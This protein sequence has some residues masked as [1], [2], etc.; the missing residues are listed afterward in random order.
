M[1]VFM[2]VLLA[3]AVVGLIGVAQQPSCPVPPGPVVPNDGAPVGLPPR[4]W[5][6]YPTGVLPSYVVAGDF[7]VDG[8]LDL[9]VSCMGTNDVWVYGNQGNVVRGVFTVPGIGGGP[10]ARVPTVLN[11][12][13]MVVG[14]FNGGF[15]GY[16]DIAVLSGFTGNIGA[17]AG[18][19]TPLVAAP[20]LFGPV[21]GAI[22]MAGGNFDNDGRTDF[23]LVTAGA[24]TVFSSAGGFAATPLAYAATL[25][26]PVAVV[27]GDFDQN[28]WDDVAVLFRAPAPGGGG[29]IQVFYNATAAG[30]VPPA[31]G[32]VPPVVAFFPP[33]VY[34]AAAIPAYL[35]P[36]GMDVGDFNADGYPDLVIV[37]NTIAA[38]IRGFAQVFLNLVP[39]GTILG[40]VPVS[41][42]N[43]AMSTWGFDARFVE[44]LDADG[45]GRDDFAVANWG[46][47]TVTIF[48]TD[49]LPLLPDKRPVDSTGYCLCDEQRRED[50]L[51]ITFKLFK[52]ELQCGHFPVGLA[53]GDFD[54]NGKAHLAV[55]LQS[56]DKELCAQNRSCIEVDFDIACGFSPNQT[57]HSYDKDK[58]SHT[59]SECKDKGSA[60][61]ATQ[62]SESD[63]SG[64][65]GK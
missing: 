34:L 41:L 7:N 60:G 17:I 35:A 37:E 65:S 28:G 26:T 13:Q 31:A 18:A 10:T 42:A 40:F 63:T 25:A 48:L 51:D 32:A 50:L 11:P 2:R 6:C 43:S 54:H 38:P 23:V 14:Q 61:S 47:D 3:L 27:T 9:A 62:G 30:A 57:P 12:I 64:G 49:A 19:A 44:V 36:V 58:E 59:C 33:F 22:C 46:S 15:D 21:P 55:A 53:A 29:A 24:A 52:I 45:N 56:A 39:V 16:P 5:A 8:W 1:R 20:P 4:A